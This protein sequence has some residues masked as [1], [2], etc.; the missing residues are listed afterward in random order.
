MLLLLPTPPEHCPSMK[1]NSLEEFFQLKQQPKDTP[2][3]DEHGNPVL[4]IVGNQILCDGWWKSP[5]MDSYKASISDLHAANGQTGSGNPVECVIF[6]NTSCQQ[7]IL[8][9]EE[10]YE[11]QGCSQL[12]P[13]D[14]P[15]LRT[16]Y[17]GQN[18]IVCLQYWCI[19][20]V[21]ILLALRHD[22]FHLINHTSFI[23]VL[24]EITIEQVDCLVLRIMGKQT[25]A[26]SHSD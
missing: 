10:A 24:F 26:M 2:L 3:K 18:T 23:P 4:D 5:Y 15:W 1:T 14:V 13:S 16:Y 12:L 17:V 20:V 22:E 7:V 8:A 21:A 19:I 25:S 6:T 11:E 9:D